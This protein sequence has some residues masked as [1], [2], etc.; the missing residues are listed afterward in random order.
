MQIAEYVT[1]FISIIVGIAVGDLLISFH[2][3]LRARRR[4]KWH[5]VPLAIALFG[6]LLIV[7]YWWS[8]FYWYE[9]AERLSVAAFLPDLAQF[10]VLFLVLAASL[11]DEVPAEGLDLKAWYRD[12]AA[13]YWTLA[14]L[15]LLLD[16]VVGGARTVGPD[17]GLLE[18]AY[19][20]LNDLLLL[21]VVIAL[22][23]VRKFAFHA[24]VVL[25]S[26]ANLAWVA[27]TFVIGK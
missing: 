1:V 16:I 12:N 11:P 13:T 20:K 9:Q 19:A 24:A 7:S 25:L 5:W 10:V 2:R 8:A 27:T 21:P 15:S 6:L 3:L 17:G 23:F 18:L 22:I 26:L 14:T 4:V